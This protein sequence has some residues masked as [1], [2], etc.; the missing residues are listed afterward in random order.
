MCGQPTVAQPAERPVEES[1]GY[2]VGGSDAVYGATPWMAMLV[3]NRAGT[4]CG[5]ALIDR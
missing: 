2:I 4:F 1:A 3:E 5:G